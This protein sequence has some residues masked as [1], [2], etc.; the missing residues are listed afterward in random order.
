VNIQSVIHDLRDSS[1]SVTF[2][3]ADGSISAISYSRIYDDA[4]LLLGALQD[5]GLGPLCRL[6]LDL[7]GLRET[8]TAL[9]A[10]W[11]GGMV[12]MIA[13]GGRGRPAR[14]KKPARSAV[15]LTDSAGAG[16]MDSSP[17]P[18]EGDN[19][20]HYPSSP[21]SRRGLPSRMLDGDT[22]LLQLT[23]GSAAPPRCAV[24]TGRNLWEGARASSVVA[25]PGVRERYLSWLPLSHIFGVL[26]YHIVPLFNGFDQFLMDTAVFMRN[27]AVWLRTCGEWGCTVTGSTQFGLGLSLRAV[28]SACASS[29][30]GIPDLSGINVCFCGG[31]NLDAASLFTFERELSRF[32]WRRGSLCPAYGLSEATMG[33]SYK[34]PGEEILVDRIDSGS[35]SIGGRLRFLKDGEGGGVERVSLGVLDACNEVQVRDLAGRVLSEERLGVVHLRGS[36]ICAGYDPAELPPN[37][38]HGGWFDTGDLGYI[39]GGHLAIFARL[40]EIICHNGLNYSLRDLEESAR[41]GRSNE[42]AL[43]EARDGLLLFGL[44]GDAAA[45]RE[46]SRSVTDAW[47]VP[48]AGIVLLRQMPRSAKGAIDRLAL[49]VGWESGMYELCEVCGERTGAAPLVGKDAVMAAIWS[50]ILGVPLKALTRESHFVELGG[51]SLSFFD[52]AA[53]IERE[54]HIYAETQDLMGSP[55]LRETAALVE[56]L[57]KNARA[58]AWTTEDV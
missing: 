49:S 57:E 23:S 3:E 4:L 20:L 40:K 12:P 26:G 25:R 9:W 43:V 47:G 14:A 30:Y 17:Q 6:T 55:T 38:G 45:L 19:T 50:D 7:G 48:L 13:P 46:A 22:A 35:V 18:P 8:V 32:G 51:D 56:E 53:A 42:L 54:W 10:C 34:P 5:E 27:P 29:E 11:L 39:R 15:L 41:K 33:V 37:P 24:L 52:L 2:L 1:A 58:A 16:R 36:N 44:E 21:L 28:L 31:E